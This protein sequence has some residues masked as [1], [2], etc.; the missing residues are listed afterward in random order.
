MI[1]DCLAKVAKQLTIDKKTN[2]QREARKSPRASLHTPLHLTTTGTLQHRHGRA[3]SRT[4]RGAWK[5]R[6]VCVCVRGGVNPVSTS[7]TTKQGANNCGDNTPTEVIGT[8][9]LALR[10]C[11]KKRK[12]KMSCHLSV[13]AEG[14]SCQ[15]PQRTHTATSGCFKNKGVNRGD[16][17]SDRSV[18]FFFFK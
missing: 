6:G 10:N 9:F 3:R 17:N 11:V 5:E 4:P 15:F 7:Q 18:R 1:N 13:V 8:L 16:E 14:T 12:R 2:E